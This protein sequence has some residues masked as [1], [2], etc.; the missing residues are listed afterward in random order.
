MDNTKYI[1]MNL[2]KESLSATVMN[3]ARRTVMQ[4]VI[5]TKANMI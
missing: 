4:C 5:E 3:A 2:R 1:G